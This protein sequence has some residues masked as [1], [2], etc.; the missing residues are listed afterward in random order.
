M[1]DTHGD[2][3]P[4][5]T[6]HYTDH[7]IKWL[8]LD[9]G[10]GFLSP[11]GRQEVTKIV[12][13]IDLTDKEV[14]DIGVGL[15]GP[16]CALVEDLGAAL[17]TGIDVEALIL[18]R[19]AEIVQAYSLSD[20]VVLK[21]VEPGPLPFKD[22]TFDLVFSKD[23]I[24]HIP[25]TATLFREAYRV[26][27]PDGWFAISDWYCGDAPFTEEM[28]TWVERL[29]IGLAMKPIETDRKRLEAAGFVDVKVLDRTTWFIEDTGRLIERLRDSDLTEYT[30]TLG[31]KDAQDGILFAEERMNL[32]IQEQLRPSHLRGRKL[33]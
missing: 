32:A 24:I 26:L 23:A 5:E 30:E 29:D 15:A 12:E 31:E 6:V 27:K 33:R 7:F 17:V 18:K 8:E 4:N 11:G 22:E 28:T 19:A 21:R 20:H 9:F 13:G 1:S 3:L 25:D 10:A 16:A 2:Y 14:L